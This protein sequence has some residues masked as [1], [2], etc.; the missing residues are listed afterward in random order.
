ML[1]HS[2]LNFLMWCSIT[3]TS[4]FGTVLSPRISVC[5]AGTVAYNRGPFINPV[6]L[7][8]PFLLSYWSFVGADR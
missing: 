6:S 5:G 1:S 3:E 8:P 4:L 7:P 2:V